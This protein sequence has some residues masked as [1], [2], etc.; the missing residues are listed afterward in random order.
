MLWSETDVRFKH[1]NQQEVLLVPQMN[2]LKFEIK[3]VISIPEGKGS[4][5]TFKTFKPQQLHLHINGLE[6]GN[7]GY[8]KIDKNL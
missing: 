2:N 4:H 3:K 6:G 7:A 8:H 5:A 1:A